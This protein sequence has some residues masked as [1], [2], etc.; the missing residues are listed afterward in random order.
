MRTSIVVLLLVLAL[1]LVGLAACGTAAPAASS[2]GKGE[3]VAGEALFKIECASCHSVLAGVNLAGP[4]LASIGAKGEQSLR[5]AIVNPNAEVTSGFDKGIM[6]DSFGKQL[7]TP[8]IDDLVAY[9]L[10]LK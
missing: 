2:G 8:Q 7:T 10:T 9:L 6:P 5:E 1:A 4:S 3:A